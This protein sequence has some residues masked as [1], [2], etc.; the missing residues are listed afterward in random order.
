MKKKIKI[1]EKQN[2]LISSWEK[3]I[4]NNYW[5]YHKLQEVSKNYT[6]KKIDRTSYWYIRK[7][8]INIITQIYAFAISSEI[9]KIE[10]S[11]YCSNAQICEIRTFEGFC[12]NCN[13]CA[14]S[15]KCETIAINNF[16][17][18]CVVFAQTVS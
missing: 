10:N 3:A 9:N 18:L 16:T 14:S 4:A 7:K 12:D 8:E 6:R 17:L 15:T 13:V 11:K 1:I 5:R 2:N